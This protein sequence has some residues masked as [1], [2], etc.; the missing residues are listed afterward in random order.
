[1]GNAVSPFRACCYPPLLRCLHLSPYHREPMGKP[2]S[3]CMVRLTWHSSF[4]ECKRRAVQFIALPF[5]WTIAWHCVCT[6]QRPCQPTSRPEKAQPHYWSQACF[7]FSHTV[8]TSPLTS[9][10]AQRLDRVSTSAIQPMRA[11]R[12]R[13]KRAHKGRCFVMA[14]NSLSVIIG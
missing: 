8:K 11:P 7:Y 14:Q 10:E 9:E 4:A 1:M 12:A 5:S 3:S 2:L 6:L 13:K